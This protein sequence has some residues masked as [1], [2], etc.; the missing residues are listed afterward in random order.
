MASVNKNI[1]AVSWAMPPLVLPRALQISRLLKQWSQRGWRTT[2]L[3]VDPEALGGSLV[4]DRE[5]QSLYQTY[6][7]TLPLY[8]L[9]RSLTL[10]AL[11]RLLPVCREI[12]DEKRLWAEWAAHQG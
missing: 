6:Y 7:Q 3:T 8:S 12:P 4:M 1:L 5:L 10:S 11:F 9:E 2:V